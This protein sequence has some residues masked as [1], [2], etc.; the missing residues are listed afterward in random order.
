[1]EGTEAKS[2][3]E[4]VN[5]YM[6]LILLINESEKRL[7]LSELFFLSINLAVVLFSVHYVASFLSVSEGYA[8]QTFSFFFILCCFSIGISISAYWLAFS[9]RLQLKLK[10]RYFQARYLERKMDC[11]G[12][13]I[14][15]DE[16]PYFLPSIHR[17]ESPDGKETLIYPTSGALRMDGFIGNA[18]PR[19]LSIFMPGVFITIYVAMII[20]LLL[21]LYF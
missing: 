11:I 5:K 4:T 19:H 15:T 20:G 3:S 10:L 17:L 16:S 18:Q 8:A 14:F 1:M 13:Y 9:M 6:S 12:E 7:N 21:K 2:N